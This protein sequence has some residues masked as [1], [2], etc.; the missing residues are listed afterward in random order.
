M[1]DQEAYQNDQEQQMHQFGECG[2][3]TRRLEPEMK[4]NG[5]E[6]NIDLSNQG[7]INRFNTA[8]QARAEEHIKKQK[9][10]YQ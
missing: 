9:K 5:I 8:I 4:Q 3:E 7:P 2:N 10:E 6:G 1:V